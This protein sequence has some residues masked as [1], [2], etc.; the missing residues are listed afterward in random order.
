MVRER[1]YRTIV[2]D[3]GLVASGGTDLFLAGV[4]REVRTNARV[5]V[6]SWAGEGMIEGREL[7]CADDRHLPLVCYS[8][9]MLGEG[10]G[11]DFYFFTL[12]AAPAA[13]MHFMSQDE[14]RCFG[15][16]E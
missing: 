3:N 2:P 7:G 12:M 9:L 8:E 11:T 10:V 13:D 5:G 16:V 1:G 6:H 15:I 14:L 4:R